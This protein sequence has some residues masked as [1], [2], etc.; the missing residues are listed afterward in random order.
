VN[1]FGVLTPHGGSSI[2]GIAWN[3]H[4][5]ALNT[6]KPSGYQTKYQNT[7]PDNPIT[8]WNG[9]Q[10]HHFAAFFQ[11]GY[12]YGA[13]AGSVTAFATEWWQGLESGVLNAGDVALGEAAAQIGAN[14]KA[15][16]ISMSDVASIIQSTLCLH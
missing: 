1:N 13:A 9:D 12:K 14:L 7:L 15:G 10:G 11:F 3:S 4:P 6:G 16:K 2:A 5:V 8:G